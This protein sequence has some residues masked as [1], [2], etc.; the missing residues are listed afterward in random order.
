MFWHGYFCK[1]CDL[2]PQNE[3]KVA[4]E[5]NGFKSKP[6]RRYA[7]FVVAGH[8]WVVVII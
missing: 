1:N 4:F 2:L 8:G 6:L 7:H 3:C 5:P